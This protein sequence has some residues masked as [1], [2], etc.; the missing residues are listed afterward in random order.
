MPSNTS[1]GYVFPPS[2]RKSRSGSEI[3]EGSSLQICSVSGSKRNVPSQ[4]PGDRLLGN[5]QMS[6]VC[7]CF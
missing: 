2:T 1:A 6:N 7:M 4:L 5:Y 3:A